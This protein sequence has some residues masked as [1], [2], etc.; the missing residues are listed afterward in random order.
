MEQCALFI[1]GRRPLDEVAQFQDDINGMGV[2]EYEEILS[3]EYDAFKLAFGMDDY[4][5]APAEK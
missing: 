3:G 4:L 5:P 2:L 1:T